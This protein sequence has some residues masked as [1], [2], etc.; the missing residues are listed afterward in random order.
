M[1]QD[2]I[3]SR[4]LEESKQDQYRFTWFIFQVRSRETSAKTS[5][6]F[7]GEFNNPDDRNL[8]VTFISWFT[9]ELHS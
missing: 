7:V 5:Y 9:Q 1:D 6:Q 4:L 8:A 2:V 3:S